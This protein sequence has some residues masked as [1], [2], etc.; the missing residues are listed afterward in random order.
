VSSQSDT[1][2]GRPG[3]RARLAGLQP[4]VLKAEGEGAATLLRYDLPDGPAVL[5]EWAP[6]RSRLMRWWAQLQMRREIRNYRLLAGCPGIPDYLDHEGNEALLIRYVKASPIHRKMPPALLRMGLDDLER[7][8]GAVH[9]RRFVHLDL[10]QK[11]NALIDAG[12]HAW[13][14]DLGQGLDCSRGWVRGALFPLLA[15]IDRAAVIKFRARYAPDTLDPAKR[16]R[17]VAQYG[18]RRLRWPKRLGRA[19]RRRVTGG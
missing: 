5:K 11:L 9:A 3:L 13:L 12:G 14:V 7:V 15:R 19:L 8:L 4:E 16:E 2:V 18:E 6:R 1:S 17:L 10:H